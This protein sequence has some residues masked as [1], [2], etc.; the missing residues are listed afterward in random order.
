[1]EQKQN[2]T[3]TEKN[4]RLRRNLVHLLCG[5]Y[6]VY[7]AYQLGS[8]FALGIADKG[9]TGEMIVSLLGA[10]VFALV[11]CVLLV[12]LVRRAAAQRKTKDAEE[13]NT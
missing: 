13:E 7:L 12:N 2:T 4:A 6:L 8:A 11:G 10:A 1:M 5:G 3:N 9:W